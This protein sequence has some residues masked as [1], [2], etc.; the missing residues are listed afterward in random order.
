MA[1]IIDISDE[2]KPKIVSQADARDARSG[3]LRQGRC[4]DLAG[5]TSFTYGSHYCS[6]D[7]KQNA[8]TLACGYFNSGIRV[9]D[10]RDPLRPK[11]IAYYNPA[12]TTTP[13][14]GSNHN[15]AGGWVAGG[16]DWCS[17]QV[18]L[19][20][21]QGTLWTTCQDNGL[22]VL[23]FTQ[24]RVAVR[25]KQHAAG[26]AE[27]ATAFFIRDKP[28]AGTK[29]PAHKRPGPCLTFANTWVAVQPA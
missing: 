10:I 9:F 17:A 8:T 22:L 18:H 6:V 25:R 23:K 13:S 5:L 20:A 14:P 28:K 21:E 11:E 3:E 15:R 1:R 26:T 27:L 7:N 4:P 29:A 16:P 24:R 12:G 19:D 2:T